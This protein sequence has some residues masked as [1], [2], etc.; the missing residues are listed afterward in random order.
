MRCELRKYSSSEL[1]EAAISMAVEEE[2]VQQRWSGL[3]L[4]GTT[5]ELRNE[6]LKRSSHGP[7]PANS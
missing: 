1:Y 6:L 3:P 2:A 7:H 5:K 4:T